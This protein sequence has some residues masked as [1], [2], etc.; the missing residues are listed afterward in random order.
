MNSIETLVKSEP[1]P[2][3]PDTRVS[4]RKLFSIDTDMEKTTAYSHADEHVPDVDPDYLFAAILRSR[5]SPASR[6]TV[7]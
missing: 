4:V 1:A 6:L 2:G 5:S 7:G 3:L